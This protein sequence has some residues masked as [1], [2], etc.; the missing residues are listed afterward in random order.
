MRALH[1][2]VAS[3]MALVEHT[4]R[5]MRAR[6]GAIADEFERSKSDVTSNPQVPFVE[7]PPVTTSCVTPFRLS[8]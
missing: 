7:Q 2:Y 3:A 5:I 4:R 1:N 8:A 6:S